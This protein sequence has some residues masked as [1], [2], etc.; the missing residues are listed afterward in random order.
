MSNDHPRLRPIDDQLLGQVAGIRRELIVEA[1]EP[2]SWPRLIATLQA[3]PERQ[4]ALLRALA[5]GMDDLDRIWWT[6][7][8]ARLEEIQ[9]G[10]AGRSQALV[11]SERW[12]R[13]KDDAVRYEAFQK[14]QEESALGPPAMVG[15]AVFVAGPSLAPAGQPVE[16]PPAG[17]AHDTALGVLTATAASPRLGDNGFVHV[18]RIG[19]DIAAGGEGREAARQALADIQ[20][21]VQERREPV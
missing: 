2:L 7:L 14:G 6:C 20:G 16:P 9:S 15:M 10:R 19:L 11:L 4:P 12:L 21:Q 5:W 8:A 17:M 1:G 3:A 13:E 18:N